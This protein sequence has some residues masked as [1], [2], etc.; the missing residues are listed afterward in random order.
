M[1]R[2]WWYLG[3]RHGENPLAAVHLMNNPGIHR[4]VHADLL[5]SSHDEPVPAVP[6]LSV[7]DRGRGALE[8]AGEAAAATDEVE[9]GERPRAADDERDAARRV[10]G[11]PSMASWRG[12][13]RSVASSA[14]PSAS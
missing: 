11:E 6:V 7:G 1:P 14:K 9:H 3:R 12:K 13:A 10:H 4:I 5:L 8:A 2:Q